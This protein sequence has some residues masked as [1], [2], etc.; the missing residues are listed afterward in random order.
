[1]A[2]TIICSVALILERAARTA[3]A[4]GR[5]W[6]APL[7]VM[8]FL[9]CKGA[10]GIECLFPQD[11]SRRNVCADRTANIYPAAKRHIWMN[12]TTYESDMTLN[13]VP[14]ITFDATSIKLSE[15]IL[16]YTLP[17]QLWPGHRSAPSGWLRRRN[18][19]RSSNILPRASIRGG[20]QLRQCTGHRGRR[21]L[22]LRYLWLI[23]GNF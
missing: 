15:L 13:N 19:G 6:A 5:L 20:Q 2:G 3:G 18:S 7:P 11:K 4:S 21:L 8:R 23:E 12:P 1:M 10:P 16:G 22:P 17:Q 9:P 14:A